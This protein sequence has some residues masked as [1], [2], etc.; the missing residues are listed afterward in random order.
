[1]CSRIWGLLLVSGFIN[2]IKKSSEKSTKNDHLH[3]HIHYRTWLPP[4]LPPP[5]RWNIYGF[6]WYFIYAEQKYIENLSP[7]QWRS[8][9]GLQWKSDLLHKQGDN[10]RTTS[11]QV[12]NLLKDLHCQGT[13][14][15]AVVCYSLI[16]FCSFFFYKEWPE[17]GSNLAF[18]T[19]SIRVEDPDICQIR[20]LWPAKIF[21]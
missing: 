3:L 20:F 15:F 4:S 10:K 7:G 13:W 16:I 19:H 14:Q 21:H 5:S 6:Q 8:D 12:P 18:G 2:I 1:M 11:Y 17:V 9:R